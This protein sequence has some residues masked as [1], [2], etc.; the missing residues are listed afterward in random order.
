MVK[1][2]V[3]DVFVDVCTQR[4]YLDAAGARPTEN[5]AELSQRVK[6]LMALARWAKVPLISCVEGRRPS[7][8]A[9]HKIRDC[10]IGTEGQRKPC[11]TVMPSHTCVDTDNCPCIDLDLLRQFQQA[12]FVKTHA[13]PFA[14]P[15]LDRLLTEMSAKRFVLFGVGIE[16]TVRT[17]AL[18]LL[19]RHRKVTIVSDACGYWDV[20]AADMVARQLAAKHCTM[21][22][23]SEF[24]QRRMSKW[25]SSSTRLRRSRFV[26]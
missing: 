19:M 6:Q 4:D 7:D 9:G 18:G 21:L 11:F 5:A 8:V 25:M 12:I 26:A 10:V 1:A 22:T 15:K 24:I 16:S 14:N 23:T 3:S 13:D 20:E 17:L 2:T